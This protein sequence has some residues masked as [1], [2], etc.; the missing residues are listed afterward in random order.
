MPRKTPYTYDPS[1]GNWSS[2]SSN[3]G[4]NNST[5]NT[6]SSNNSGGSNNNTSSGNNSG[7]SNSNGNLSSSNT[8]NKS[9][10]GSTEK[11]IN[12][13]EINTLI[14]TLNFIVTTQ[15]I[16]LK[17]GDTVN[18]QGLGKYLSGKYYVKEVIRSIS[19]NNGYEHSATVIKTDFGTKLKKVSKKNSKKKKNK[20]KKTTKKVKSSKS[21]SKTPKRYY[22]VKSG[23]TLYS[24]AA[25][26]YGKG[27]SWEKISKANNN[28]SYKA[29]K[30][31]QK[32]VIP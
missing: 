26:Y 23:D 11:K 18:L 28:V 9:A 24:I 3:S 1:S 25:K 27:S 30:V 14:G 12:Y 6:G 4:S 17:A 10:T 19:S 32:L 22:V 13:I 5:S 2:S 8:D 21:K 7:G 29:I 31:G 16:K 20:K 15:T